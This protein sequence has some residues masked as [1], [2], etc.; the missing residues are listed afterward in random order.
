MCAHPLTQP[1]VVEVPTLGRHA[2]RW[3]ELVAAMPLPSPFLRSW[4]VEHAAVGRPR[5]LIVTDAEELIGGVAFQ[6]RREHGVE[7]VSLVGNGPLE[8]DHL[9]AVY[10]VD[11]RSDVVVA[12]RQWL[13]GRRN[14]VRD[15]RQVESAPGPRE[16]FQ[17]VDRH[18]CVQP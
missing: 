10:R 13:S 3:D 4:W 17:C 9:D 6:S 18:E 15:L 1:T 11:R 14:C 5:L 7:W 8:P 16:G 12:L 2:E